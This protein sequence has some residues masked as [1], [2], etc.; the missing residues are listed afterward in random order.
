MVCKKEE[1]QNR[2]KMRHEKTKYDAKEKVG[3]GVSGKGKMAGGDQT[4]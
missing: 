3:G 1:R 2:K 4:Y